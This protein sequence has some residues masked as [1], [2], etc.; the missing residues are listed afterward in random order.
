MPA[1]VHG[2]LKDIDTALARSAATGAADALG[3]L[4]NRHSQR[5]YALCLRMTRDASVAEDLTQEV[6]I[7]LL[8]KI[9]SFR[10]E[11]HF[12]TWLH[13]LTVNKVLMYLRHAKRRKEH[14]LD[15]LEMVQMN[16]TE[17]GKSTAGSQVA[18]SIAL[19]A[20]V[21]QLPPGSRAVF[22]LFSVEGYKHEE[23]ASI[24]GCSVGNSKSQLHKA[25][26]KLKRL[27]EQRK[28]SETA[29]DVELDHS[30]RTPI[31]RIGSMP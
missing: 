8:R 28:T 22:L 13:R 23:I 11:S 7:H 24:F 14:V 29:A 21:D 6:F 25:R 9:G 5:V 2:R 17:K 19:D 16:S 27:L 12:T 4:Y 18:D 30:L 3:D 31:N 26:K 15:P 1:V 20:A 10:G